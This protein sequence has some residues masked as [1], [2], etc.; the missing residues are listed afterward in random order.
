MPM[1]CWKTVNP[2]QLENTS[3]F[4][5]YFSLTFKA[6]EQSLESDTQL[7]KKKIWMLFIT[8]ISILYKLLILEQF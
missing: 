7:V 8:L 4:L 3:I 1:S 2:F 6:T 5:F